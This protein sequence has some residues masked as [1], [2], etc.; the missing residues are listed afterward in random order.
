[1]SNKDKTTLT[2][3]D[4]G[5]DSA[6][7][8]SEAERIE[9]QTAL[10]R[11]R[12]GVL[13]VISGRMV[14]QVYHLDQDTMTVGRDANC[15]ISFPEEAIS[16]EHVRLSQDEDRH[17][18]ITDCKSTNGTFVNGN[19]ITHH[20]LRDG[21]KIQI[22]DAL[23]FKFAYQDS[24]EEALQYRE[25]EQSIRDPLTGIFTKIYFLSRLREEFAYASR[26]GEPLSI[27]LADI[28]HLR[29]VN[30]AF[31]QPAGDIVLRR[32]S[33]IMSRS[34]REE[35][36]FARYG[37]A[38]FITL[39]RNQDRERAFETADRVRRTVQD[40]SFDHKDYTI[41]IT[42]SCGVSTLD[43]GNFED[44]REMLN[45]AER[46]LFQAKR[47]GRNRTASATTD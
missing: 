30:N 9:R 36:V 44:P 28:D 4:G 19:Q 5:K 40:A 2:V 43:D 38:E 13:T 16:R 35:D 29:H 24:R 42:I 27:F 31:G 21:D 22:G 6:E 8:R 34:L 20:L 39:L 17:V 33:E 12:H 10:W 41:S 46:F 32:L 14:G 23:I 3:V 37:A 47:K 25:H 11:N 7:G 45:E 15:D 18:F 1:M 26:R